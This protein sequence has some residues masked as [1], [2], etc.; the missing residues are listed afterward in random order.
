MA[1]DILTI[2]VTSVA[3]DAAFRGGGRILD[4]S[5]ISLNRDI[6]EALVTVT[7]WVKSRKNKA[8]SANQ[9]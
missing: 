8:L 9:K 1:R 3:L 2:L 4:D 5:H 6:V 7:D